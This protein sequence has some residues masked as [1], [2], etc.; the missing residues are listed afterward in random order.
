M[1][2]S[3]NTSNFLQIA[4]ISLKL[5]VIC[6][7][8]AVLVASVNYLTEDRILL[9]QKQKTAQALSEIYAGDGLDFSVNDNGEYEVFGTDGTPLGSCELAQITLSGDIEAIYVIKNT[10]GSVF[11]YCAEVTPMGFKNEVGVLVAVNPDVT[12]KD[13]QIISLSDTKGIGD[14]V[15][16]RDFLDKFI[17]KK[18]GFS[19]NSADLSDLIIAGATKTSKPVTMAIDEALVK[20]ADMVKGG[21]I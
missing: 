13:V 1:Q 20:I 14:K 6:S 4:G 21:A 19:Q 7:F 10:D 8:I 12:V 17:G 16:K 3:K 5:L 11:G 15:T 9:N 18:S 2:N